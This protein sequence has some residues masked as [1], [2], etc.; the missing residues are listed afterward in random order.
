MEHVAGR[1]K[2]QA[3]TRIRKGKGEVGLKFMQI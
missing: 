2:V 3:E 1:D